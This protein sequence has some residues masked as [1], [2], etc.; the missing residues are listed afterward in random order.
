MGGDELDEIGDEE[1]GAGW[2]RGVGG[3]GGA[4]EAAGGFGCGWEH[5]GGG[6]AEESGC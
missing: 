4:G 2:W 5:G 6:G 1:D 3:R